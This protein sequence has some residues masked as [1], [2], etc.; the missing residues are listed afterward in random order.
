MEVF[1][2]KWSLLL[3]DNDDID[4]IDEWLMILR[5]NKSI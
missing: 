4:D 1:E 3:N 5:I 2:W